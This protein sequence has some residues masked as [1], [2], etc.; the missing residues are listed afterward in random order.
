MEEASVASVRRISSGLASWS[1]RPAGDFRVD[2]SPP[3]NEPGIF[4]EALSVVSLHL[5]VDHTRRGAGLPAAADTLPR[6]VG[7]RPAGSCF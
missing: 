7:T 6:I 4:I 1:S 2:R 3:G 5:Q